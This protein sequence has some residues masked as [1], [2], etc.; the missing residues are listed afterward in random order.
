MRHLK[1]TITTATAT[2]VSSTVT[3]PATEPTRTPVV[4]I[5]AL[6]IVAETNRENNVGRVRSK[7]QITSRRPLPE[8]FSDNYR[9]FNQTSSFHGRKRRASFCFCLFSWLEF[10]WRSKRWALGLSIC[11]IE[12]NKWNNYSP[13]RPSY[14][15]YCSPRVNNHRTICTISQMLIIIVQCVLFPRC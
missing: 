10:I 4:V 3:A 6:V 2:T 12:I 1:T 5:W 8:M 11:M 9:E 14:T 13:F 7:R 15:L